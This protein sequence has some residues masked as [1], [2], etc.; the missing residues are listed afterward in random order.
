MK[1]VKKGTAGKVRMTRDEM[2]MDIETNDVL[3]ANRISVK[4]ISFKTPSSMPPTALGSSDLMRLPSSL[5]FTF[6]F[7]TFQTV[8][9]EEV[10]LKT[11]EQIERGNIG[12]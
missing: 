2:R 11:E 5:F 4:F 9:T 7:Y 12:K 6:K 3:K 8:Q 10:L 1:G